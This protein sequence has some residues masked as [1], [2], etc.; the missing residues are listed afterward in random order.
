MKRLVPVVLVFALLF[1][2]SLV[3]TPQRLAASSSS[4]S[5]VLIQLEARWIAAILKG[6]RATVASILSAR[7]KHITGDGAL[8]D[9]AQELATITKEPFTIA[10]SQ[11]TVDYDPSGDA[12]VLRGLDTI[13]QPGKPMR[14]RRFTDVFFKVN[15]AWMAVSAQENV[16]AP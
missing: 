14:R 9:R 10:L 15:G 3:L 5:D 1:A 13:T 2:T 4:E 16:I 6:D 7:F 12:A 11:Q 8:M